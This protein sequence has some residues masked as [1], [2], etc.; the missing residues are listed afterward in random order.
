MC[1]HASTQFLRSFLIFSRSS[2]QSLACPMCMSMS[3][4]TAT[5]PLMSKINWNKINPDMKILPLASEICNALAAEHARQLRCLFKNRPVFFWPAKACCLLVLSC[6]HKYFS[7]TVYY[8]EF[9]RYTRNG[10]GAGD[11]FYVAIAVVFRASC[12]L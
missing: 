5:C 6:I 1:L 8:C 7:G 3:L 2:G 12:L 10:G 9:S 4:K 11:R